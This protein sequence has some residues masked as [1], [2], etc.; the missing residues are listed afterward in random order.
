MLLRMKLP[1]N[2]VFACYVFMASTV[3]SQPVVLQKEKARTNEQ[4]RSD[5]Q[6]IRSFGA[7]EIAK[8]ETAMASTR[9]DAQTHLPKPDLVPFRVYGGEGGT[10]L[11][12]DSSLWGGFNSVGLQFTQGGYVNGMFSS[13]GR[14]NCTVTVSIIRIFTDEKKSR[15]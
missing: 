14:C 6:M 4:T 8:L 10:E 5:T 7:G 11:R 13:S 9:L 3:R 15:S 2:Q 12:G 1:G